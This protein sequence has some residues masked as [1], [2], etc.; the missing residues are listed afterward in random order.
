M[1]KTIFG[2][3]CSLTSCPTA[4]I[5][6]RKL[7]SVDLAFS[8]TV[9]YYATVYTSSGSTRTSCQTS[10]CWKSLTASLN[11]L[12][13]TLEHHQ[14]CVVFHVRTHQCKLLSPAPLLHLIITQ[15]TGLATPTSTDHQ[16]VLHSSAELQML[17][18][19]PEIRSALPTLT[20]VTRTLPMRH[21]LAT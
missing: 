18:M 12:V 3:D 11:L 9:E 2:W 20:H 16:R 15:M 19:H 5:S 4:V 13:L 21:L 14:S 1:S 8:H 7:S 17:R 10:I 6:T